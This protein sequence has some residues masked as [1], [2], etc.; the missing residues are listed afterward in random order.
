MQTPIVNLG[1]FDYLNPQ[2]IDEDFTYNKTVCL[3]GN[4]RK[5]NF[6]KQLDMKDAKLKVFGPNAPKTFGKGV[7]Y[8]GQFS[9]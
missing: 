1:L 7:E 3:A 8:Q 4:L 6:L 5:S 9:P 2:P